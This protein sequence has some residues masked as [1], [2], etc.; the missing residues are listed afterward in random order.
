MLAWG[1][2]LSRMRPAQCQ[3]HAQAAHPFCGTFAG[4]CAGWVTP[5]IDTVCFWPVPAACTE[6]PTSSNP[7]ARDQDDEPRQRAAD[8]KEE[9]AAVSG[10]CWCTACLFGLVISC[11]QA[12]CSGSGWS[13][14]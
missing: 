11:N 6:R 9:A 7:M 8:Q 1:L 12:D 3:Y 14:L 4:I 13:R 2:I 5:T 10:R